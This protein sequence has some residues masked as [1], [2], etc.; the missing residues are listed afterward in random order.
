MSRR[1]QVFHGWGEAGAGPSLPEHAGAFLR[2]ELGVS[3]DVVARPVALEDVRLPE[4]ALPAAAREALAAV[5]PVRDDHEIRVL[6]AAGKSYTDLLGMRAGEADAPDAVVV[7][8]SADA[9]AAVLRLCAEHDVA[10]V[11]FGGGTSV[12][13]G[14][15][16]ERG[17][18][19]AVVSLD[20]GELCDVSVDERS[21]LARVGPGL[22]L[23][24]LNHALA[25]HGLTL[26]HFPQ[27]YEWASVGGCVATRSAGQAS[28]G[29]GRIEDLV[30]AADLA[31]PAGAVSTREKPASAAGPLTRELLI[32][33]EGAFGVITSVAL[34]VRPVARDPHYDGYLVRSFGDGAE[35][36]RRLVQAGAAPDIAR[37]SDEEETRI[38]LNL[39]GHGRLARMG[40]CLL[41]CGWESAPRRRLRAL[42]L[43]G[44]GRA[45]LRSRYAGPHL[46][47]D[48]MDRGVMVE[49]LETATT[50]SRLE[51]LRTA[52]TRA[53]D[54]A[55][56][57][58]HVS[59]VY[60][61]GASLY[62]TVLAA[63]D[64]ADP[65]GQWMR[66]K[67][68]A[69]DAIL[70]AGGTLTHHHAVGRDH[71]PWLAQE[72]PGGVELLRAVKD[73]LDPTGVMNP[74]KLLT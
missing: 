34:R 42:P 28:S 50:W 24:E 65:A 63:R 73:R 11:P 61:T 40:G 12:V 35:L 59:H 15:A 70:A 74:G 9:V 45:W 10:V 53:L 52:V 25:A 46:R 26:G 62:F 56:V 21:Q 16:P 29:Y 58:C 20:L 67:A 32:G 22:R 39:A 30:V 27:S 64:D 57:G 41:V 48:L 6:R 19:A 8:G 69:C 44:A 5:C 23:P 18:H 66:H 31:A 7:P 3:G 49:T 13:G 36:L 43:P 71:A 47:D 33:S 54:G 51:G 38:S 17:E 14:L 37:L 4:S 72:D 2:S 60:P 1:E 68:A 55:H